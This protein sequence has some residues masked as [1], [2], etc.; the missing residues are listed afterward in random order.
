MTKKKWFALCAVLLCVIAVIFLISSCDQSGKWASITLNGKTVS[1]RGGKVS[2]LPAPYYTPGQEP[3]VVIPELDAKPY[4]AFTANRE[5]D[6]PLGDG[7]L[8]S[9]LMIGG[10]PGDLVY[11]GV[12][13]GQTRDEVEAK[14]KDVLRES[15]E[16][17]TYEERPQRIRE[18]LSNHFRNWRDE[19]IQFVRYRMNDPKYYFIV[20]YYEGKVYGMNP[21]VDD[22]FAGAL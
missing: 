15:S 4:Y 13:F 12:T 14:L 9:F 1:F 5:S 18:V 7:Q 8:Q 3:E 6:A 19:D 2:D 11:S 20:V 22:F 17:T 16:L 21:Y 10:E